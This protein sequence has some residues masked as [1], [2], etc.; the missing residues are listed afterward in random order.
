MK[1]AM[2]ERGI[3]EKAGPWAEKIHWQGAV[4]GIERGRGPGRGQEQGLKKK[5]PRPRPLTGAGRGIEAGAR[6]FQG[7]GGPVTNSNQVL[8]VG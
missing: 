1:R 8:I 7:P 6:R 4:R 2:F 3:Y 5:T